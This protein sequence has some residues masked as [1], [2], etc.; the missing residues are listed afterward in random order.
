LANLPELPADAL[1]AIALAAVSITSLVVCDYR[2]YRPGR[3]LFKPLSSLAFLWLAHA[4]GATESGYG[5]WIFAGLLCSAAGDIL[6][7]PDNHRC[8][9]AGLL[10]FLCG[11]LCYAVGFLQNSYDITWLLLNGTA[12]LT[13]M[14]LSLRWLVPRLEVGWRAPV[15]L[16]TTVITGM[17]LSA[18]LRATQPGSLAIMAGAWGFALSDL[19]V[20][21]QRF[22]KPSPFNGLWGTPLYFF[23]QM[24]LAA[25]VAAVQS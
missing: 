16:Y 11:H 1:G 10:S 22:V 5:L 23:S 21:R 18:G 17:L 12:A 7:M 13:L 9:L 25:S 15:I 2:Q 6:L 4:M 24:L 14:A 3:Y 8:F 20:A 19:A